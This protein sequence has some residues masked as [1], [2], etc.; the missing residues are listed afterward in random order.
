MFQ[1]LINHDAIKTYGGL[2]VQLYAFLTSSSEFHASAALFPGKECPASLKTWLDGPQSRS[3]CGIE[4]KIPFLW[5]E[6]KPDRPVCRLVA[7][8]T[9][10]LWFPFK[11]YTENKWSCHRALVLLLTLACSANSNIF[12]LILFILN[13]VLCT[14]Q[15]DA[16]KQVEGKNNLFFLYIVSRWVSETNSFLM[17][18]RNAANKQSPWWGI[19]ICSSVS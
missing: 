2:R 3:G 14:S 15:C 7:T 5:R 12:L 11:I 10:L 18:L 16:G 19:N 4:E 13:T 9:M 1:C 17:L 8:L 6:S